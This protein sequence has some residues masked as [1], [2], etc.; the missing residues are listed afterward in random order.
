MKRNKR[1]LANVTTWLLVLTLMVSNFTG[2]CA[3]RDSAGSEALAAAMSTAVEEEVQSPINVKVYL[4]GKTAIYGGVEYDLTYTVEADT[5]VLKAE[6]AKGIIAYREPGNDVGKYRIHGINTNPKFNVTFVEG[7]YFIKQREIEVTI[8]DK[9]SNEGEEL[10]SL[11][12]KITKGKLAKGDKAEDIFALTTDADKDKVGVYEITLDPSVSDLSDNYRITSN[13]AKYRVEREHAAEDQEVQMLPNTQ[14]PSKDPNPPAGKPDE[15]DEP[16]DPDKPDPPAP[17]RC[18][19]G[20][21]PNTCPECNKTPDPEP[22]KC[23]HGKDPNTCPECNENLEPEPEKCP[24][25][26]DPSTCPECNKTPD[27]KPEKCPHGEDPST[28]PECNKTPD[29]EPEKCPHGEDPSTCPECNKTPD[30]EPEKCP[31][32]KDPSTCPEC[33]KIP[34]PPTPPDEGNTPD[35]GDGGTDTPENPTPP[36]P[37]ADGGTPG[38]GNGGMS[39]P[40]NT[41]P[42]APPANGGT[43]SEGSGGTETPKA[44]E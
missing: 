32:G 33:N 8:F 19:H 1:I 11:D 18:P 42:P 12:Y 22:E 36:V 14:R 44:S 35:E 13:V 31:H 2:N 9:W 23:P 17:E 16:D 21:D 15:P 40:G 28:C 10:K 41:T 39:T 5:D 7:S 20:E 34:T 38:E 24:H 43:P 27:P 4:D 6:V 30:P 25:G 3:S 26:E 37:P 29:P